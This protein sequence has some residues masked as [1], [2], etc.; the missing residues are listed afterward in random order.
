MPEGVGS[1]VA[2]E[3]RRTPLYPLYGR[4]GA[5]TTV[6]AG[7]ELPLQFAG[8][9]EEHAAVRERAG[10]FDVSHMGELELAG[11]GAEAALQ[12]LLTQD[13]ARLAVGR[14]A[15]ALMCNERGGVV[16]D[17]IAYR[18]APDRF[19]LVVNAANVE[20]DL[21][22]VRQALG[23]ATGVE[24]RDRSRDFALLALQGPR[25][26]GILARLAVDPEAVRRL[27]PF[28]VLPELEVAGVPC[29]VARTGYTGE[30]GFELLCTWEDAPA[31]WERLLAAGQPD[32]LVPCGLGARDTLRLEAGLPLYGHELAEDVS[33]LEA[34][35]ER[36]VRFDKGEFIGRDALLAQRERG[37]ARRLAGLEVLDR[38]IARQGHPVTDGEG[39]PVGEVTSGSFAPTLGKSLAMAFVPP[40]LA[41]PGRELGVVVHGRRRPARVVPLPFYRRR[42]A[43][44]AG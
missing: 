2:G 36:F 24:V 15:Y 19:L 11:P 31:L 9:R 44:E 29:A 12:R 16:D 42:R 38:A 34:G 13:V 23:G 22:H 14:A 40:A 27:P 43:R 32:G 39:R 17:L 5:R 6:F 1:A 41:E 25:A 33:P 10:L 20:K 30:D 35:L 7:W 8:I 18:L 21:E 28:G 26:E 37:L 4:Y 3:P